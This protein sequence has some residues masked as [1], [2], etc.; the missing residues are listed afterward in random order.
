MPG[1]G[2]GICFSIFCHERQE[3]EGRPC[4]GLPAMSIYYL[5]LDLREM[6]GN[7][8]QRPYRWIAE[9]MCVF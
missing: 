6:K 7:R 9:R 2:L 8:Q 1:S 3:K 4:H 5:A